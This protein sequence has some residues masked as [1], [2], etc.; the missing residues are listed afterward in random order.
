[1]YVYTNETNKRNGTIR[2]S[3]L[4][5][6][7][8]SLLVRYRLKS[9]SVYM[10]DG[11]ECVWVYAWNVGCC[12]VVLCAKFQFSLYFFGSDGVSFASYS[13][14]SCEACE[15]RFGVPFTMCRRLSF[16]CRHRIHW[17]CNLLESLMWRV[18]L[19]VA[20]VARFFLKKRGLDGA[21]LTKHGETNENVNHIKWSRILWTATSDLRIPINNLFSLASRFICGLSLYIMTTF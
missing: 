7:A 12:L 2:F 18:V 19:T 13:P 3:S 8:H 21:Y 14:R 20:S 9:F 11:C 5:R 1:M 15:I 10:C 4:L 17:C 16:G 6:C